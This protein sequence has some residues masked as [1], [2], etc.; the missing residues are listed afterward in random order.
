MVSSTDILSAARSAPQRNT[1]AEHV[2]AIETLRSKNYTWR[3]IA[4]FMTQQGVNTDHSK[5]FRFM[6]R[7]GTGRAESD[8]GFN[9]PT[10]QQYKEALS[11]LVISE[12][13]KK[14]LAYHFH[15][16]NRTANYTALSKAAN[17]P[18]YR[19]ANSQYGGL[20]RA[21]GERIGMK[22]AQTDGTPFYS[23]AIGTG[24]PF[25]DQKSD[26][27]LVMHHELAKAIEMLGWFK[28]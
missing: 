9:V 25:K 17:Q 20:G 27:Q 23:S 28:Q 15:A 6:Q 14:M 2:E 13:Q 19:F 16:H 3:E 10:A 5:L 8:E 4:D 21:L 7:H 24:N 11:D 22:F 18:N 12:D 26:Y 1:L